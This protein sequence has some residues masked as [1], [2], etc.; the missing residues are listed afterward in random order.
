MVLIILNI[1]LIFPRRDNFKKAEYS[2]FNKIRV[3]TCPRSMSEEPHVKHKIKFY[4]LQLKNFWFLGI[5][6]SKSMN[7]FLFDEDSISSFNTEFQ[8]PHS[9]G[10][11][12]NN[13]CWI[14][15]VWCYIQ[16]FRILNKKCT[17][18]YVTT[19]LSLIR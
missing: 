15:L 13:M 7:L 17:E 4:L 1:Y 14:Y 10:W 18:E 19:W 16:R 12:E 5:L 8:W 9:M 2:R 6:N 3:R 11:E